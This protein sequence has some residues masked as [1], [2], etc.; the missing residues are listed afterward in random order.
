MKKRRKN[1]DVRA[2]K[3]ELARRRAHAIKS[4]EAVAGEQFDIGSADWRA[5]VSRLLKELGVD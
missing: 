2:H 5:T 1:K 4:A 3:A